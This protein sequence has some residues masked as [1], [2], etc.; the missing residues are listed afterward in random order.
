MRIPRVF[1]HKSSYFKTYSLND[2]KLY[3]YLTSLKNQK[4]LN[5]SYIECYQLMF[6]AKYIFKYFYNP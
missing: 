2:A 1:Y 3:D 5:N 4:F 6:E